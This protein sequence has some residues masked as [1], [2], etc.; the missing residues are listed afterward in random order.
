MTDPVERPARIVDAHVH[1]WDPAR[2]DWYPYL[3][4]GLDL[5]MGDVSGMARRFDL[6]TYRA[7]AAAWDVVKWVNVAAATGTH[8]IDETLEIGRRPDGDRPD[9]VIGGVTPTA[10]VTE[11]LEQLDRQADAAGFRGVRPM[12]RFAGPLPHVDVLRALRDRGL[13]F[14]VL[15]RPAQLEEA[16]RG[17]EG[18]DDL[19]VVVE[20]AGWP[21]TGDDDERAVW[22][23]GLR[24][25]A[26]VGPAV[27]CKISGLAAPLGT[28]APATLR[29]W[30]EEALDQFGA[31]RCFF[32]SNFPVD[33]LHVTLDGLWDAYSAVTADLGPAVRDALFAGN[34]ERVY[35]I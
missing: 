25:L 4:G 21:A 16:A 20:H 35:G 30:V 33:G 13:V 18:L 32:A 3:A 2:S 23:R 19:V 11:A 1:L 8:S 24:A 22:R 31:D 10:S 5:G 6:A 29:P 7:E 15:A 27:H 34:A 28:L 12:G 14:E 26:G 17:L 9:A